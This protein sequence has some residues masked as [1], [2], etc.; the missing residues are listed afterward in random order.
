MEDQVHQGCESQH[1]ITQPKH[2]DQEFIRAIPCPH[3]RF[4]H[5]RLFHT[6]LVIIQLQVDSAK[7]RSPI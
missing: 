5:I 4:F 6:N 3:G 1:G 2:H 7:I